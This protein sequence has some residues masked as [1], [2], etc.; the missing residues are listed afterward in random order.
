MSASENTAMPMSGSILRIFSTSCPWQPWLKIRYYLER[1]F[2]NQ[3]YSMWR[4][5]HLASC[6][7]LFEHPISL[8]TPGF[9]W[10]QKSA[11]ARY[12]RYSRFAK[13][14]G[15]YDHGITKRQTTAELEIHF[16]RYAEQILLCSWL[17]LKVLD[18]ESCS[19]VGFLLTWRTITSYGHLGEHTHPW[20]SAGGNSRLLLLIIIWFI[21]SFCHVFRFCQTE[22]TGSPSMSFLAVFM[23]PSLKQDGSRITFVDLYMWV[24]KMLHGC[25]SGL[26]P[27][28][29]RA[30]LGFLCLMHVS[31]FEGAIQ[32][33]AE[34][35]SCKKVDH[36]G[37]A[38][39]C[40]PTDGYASL[41]FT[42]PVSACRCL[43]KEPC[44]TSYGQTLMIGV[45]GESHQGVQAIPLDRTSLSSSTTQTS[46]TS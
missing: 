23:S 6:L 20:Q 46:S 37:A 4:W 36:I 43:M 31:T 16:S 24:T 5:Q 42:V 33:W 44:A 21:L 38:E 15:V 27:N 19:H 40:H 3:H 8:S 18:N 11:S 13:D 32:Q 17:M 45:G 28:L 35:P 22:C 9:P 25:T 39:S 1:F 34:L 2:R 10:I 30:C 26:L 29:L 7:S 41:P 14:N 12:N